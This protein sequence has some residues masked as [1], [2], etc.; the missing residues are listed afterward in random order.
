M[1]TS[2][3]PTETFRPAAPATPLVRERVVAPVVEPAAVRAIDSLRTW[4]AIVG[5]IALAAIAVAIYAVVRA[6]DVRSG[7]TSRNGLASNA[8][9]DRISSELKALRAGAG[10]GGAGSAA[11][12]ARVD[13]LSSQVQSLRSTGTGAG[14]G[15]VSGL[16]ARVAALESTVKTLGSRPATGDQTQ[17]I[18]QLSSRVDALTSEVA[19][20]K[21]QSTP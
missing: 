14:A 5:V 15:A 19:Q 10:S 21:P 17:S 20:L 11:L 1:P 2:Q 9:V 13:Q 4:L 7:G 12:A 8:R 3:G 16:G 6:D 18:A